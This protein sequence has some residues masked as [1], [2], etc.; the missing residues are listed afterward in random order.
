[1]IKINGKLYIP[2]NGKKAKPVTAE[3][4]KY[5]PVHQIPYLYNNIVPILPLSKGKIDTF[6]F[7]KNIT[8]I[9]LKFIPKQFRKKFYKK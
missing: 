1:M 2:I 4:I 9:P 3:G 8:Y 6:S 5:I 7:G